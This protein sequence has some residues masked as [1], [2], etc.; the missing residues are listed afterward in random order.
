MSSV[1]KASLKRGRP[2]YIYSIVGVALVLLMMGIVGWMF[3]NSKE[4]TRV[5]KEDVKISVYLRTMNKDTIGQ[6]QQYISLQPY[7]KDVRY[8]DKEE[9]KKIWNTENNEDWAQFL[10]VNPL[11]ES[12]DFFARAAYVNRDSLEVIQKNIFTAFPYQITEINYPPVLVNNLDAKAKQLGLIILVIAIILGV[13]VIVSIDNTIKLA[14]FSN[15][16]LI[17]TMQMVGATRSFI[18]RPMNIRAVINGIISSTIAVALLF[19]LIMWAESY[20]PEMK[21]I[22]DIKLT[23]ILFGSMYLIGIAISVYSTHRSVLKYLKMKLDD[24]Y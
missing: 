3:L 10:D 22:R 2:S 24:L 11:P 5:F 19:I 23:A 9:A 15:R 13:V 16:F 20:F 14:M 21:Q 4:V 17:K 8:I 1:G 7:A 18:A 6:I 12:I